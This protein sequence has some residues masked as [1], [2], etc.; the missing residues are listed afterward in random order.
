[1]PSHPNH[2]AAMTPSRMFTPSRS[3]PCALALSSLMALAACGGDSSNL[4][5]TAAPVPAPAPAPTPAP[6]PTPAPE[7][8]PA[9]TPPPPA[10]GN[11]PR[12]AYALSAFDRTVSS[13]TVDASTG[14]LR[15]SGYAVTGETPLDMVAEPQGRFVYV[16]NASDGSV[17]VHR[18]NTA[19]GT[20]GP[21]SAS[22]VLGGRVPSLTAEASGRFVY[23]ANETTG[24]LTT[25]AINTTTGA[26]T[27]VGDTRVTTPVNADPTARPGLIWTEPSGKFAFVL[28][29]N[30]GAFSAY[31]INATTGV[32]TAAGP[33]LQ[34]ADFPNRFVVDP[35]GKFIYVA[36][37]SINGANLDTLAI[38]AATGSLSRV[39][40]TVDR[41]NDSLSLAVDPTGKFVYF[42]AQFV[43]NNISQAALSTYAVNQG[44]GALALVGQPAP[45]GLSTRQLSI[46]PSGQ[47]AFLPDSSGQILA[48][49][50]NPTTGA[51]SP[52][53][54]AA[55]SLVVR[56]SPLALVF[57]KGTAPV[58]RTP[59]FA[60]VANSGSN[61]VSAFAINPGTGALT[62]VA[63]PVAAGTGPG[64]V[65]VDPAGQFVYVSNKTS[66]NV[67]R[68]TLNPST[69]VLTS[70][71]Q[72]SFDGGEALSFD[73]SRRFAYGGAS[74]TP[75][76]QINHFSVDSTTGV[77]TFISRRPASTIRVASLALHPNSRFGYAI[78]ALTSRVQAVEFNTE[79]GGFVTSGSP[80]ALGGVGAQ[81]VTVDASGRFA[82]AANTASDTVSAF[83]V[84]PQTG[85]LTAVGTPIA[86]AGSPIALAIDPA[87]KFV[88]VANNSAA[89]NSISVFAINASTGSLSQASVTAAPGSNPRAITVEASGKFAYVTYQ[90][91][92]N[93]SA[94]SINPA[95]GALTAIGAPVA[96]G[97]SPVSIVTTGTVQ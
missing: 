41:G 57:T 22:T 84:D 5:S 73:T 36:S 6:S 70:N 89:S 81:S 96:A 64:A 30:H 38:D 49:N 85:A 77:F 15:Q 95:T 72:V 26:L 44:T 31:A 14:Q 7:P 2:K 55:S 75:D 79:F 94:F 10:A 35:L 29:R 21:I 58:V 24:V 39:S 52:L 45:V 17:A 13:F 92:N 87:G 11:V 82:Y 12:F 53:T 62:S 46:D 34:P 23:A 40:R 32:L 37:N 80:T 56:N 4:A 25:L 3:A 27:K 67:F 20:L 97:T 88:Y 78:N 71:G 68:Y 61:D 90:G 59:G 74:V 8:A 33:A 60:Y 50:I 91:S 43:A 42:S 54:S 9:P 28:D 51:L 18:A 93:I 48:F 76:G 19:Q 16:A 1:M 83:R 69:G 63:A 66:N 86:A 47:F 65:A